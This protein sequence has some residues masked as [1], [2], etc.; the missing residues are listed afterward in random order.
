M[1]FSFA[2]LVPD[3]CLALIAAAAMQV[4]ISHKINLI[5]LVAVERLLV[6]TALLVSTLM[7]Y[8]FKRTKNNF[9]ISSAYQEG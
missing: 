7:E 6:S 8:T 5:I 9:E 2:C 4:G 3:V 1:H